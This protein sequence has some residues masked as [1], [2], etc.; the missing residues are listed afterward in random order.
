MCA[1]QRRREHKEDVITIGFRTEK[2][3]NEPAN[4][5]A[6][7]LGRFV[8]IEIGNRSFFQFGIRFQ[9]ARHRFQLFSGY[10]YFFAIT[11][12]QRADVSLTRFPDQQDITGNGARILLTRNIELKI[13]YQ[14]LQRH[15]YGISE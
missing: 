5:R 14:Q 13:D 1:R 2:S 3:G 7:E 11:R 6:K 8:R 15:Y 10:S 12:V 9:S 4:E